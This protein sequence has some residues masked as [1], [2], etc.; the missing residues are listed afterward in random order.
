MTDTVQTQE[1]T[2]LV[3]TYFEMW[4]ATDDR[5]RAELVRRSFV[6]EGRH[7]DPLADAVGHDELA[8][9]LANVHAAYP[10]FAIERTSGID[11]HG[12]QLRFG[13][14]LVAADGTPV[15]TGLDVAEL[16]PDGRFARI[17]S[18]WGDLPGR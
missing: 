10:G 17:A 14:E 4:R 13:W 8:G 3:D 6:D 2:Q 1:T 12:D 7:V 11:Q 18:F 16:A 5:V 15:V 9:M